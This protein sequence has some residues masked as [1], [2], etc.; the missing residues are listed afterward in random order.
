MTGEH[1]DAIL[2]TAHATKDKEGWLALPEGA[3]MTIY[4]AHDGA[5]LSVSRVEAVRTEGEIVYAR[6]PKR[7]LYALARTDVYAVGFD[8]TAAGQ[9]ARRAGFG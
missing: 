3:T 7:E 1:L 2:K 6:T 5:S 9:P 8:G 4:V